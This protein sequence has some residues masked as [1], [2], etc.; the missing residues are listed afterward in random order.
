[1]KER[2]K[3]TAGSIK[4]KNEGKNEVAQRQ[5][6]GAEAMRDPT[7]EGSAKAEAERQQGK[8]EKHDRTTQ[9]S[10]CSLTLHNCILERSEDCPKERIECQSCEVSPVEQNSVMAHGK[11]RG[12]SGPP[13]EGLQCQ[14]AAVDEHSLDSQQPFGISDAVKVDMAAHMSDIKKCG[15]KFWS[16][17]RSMKSEAEGVREAEKHS[18]ERGK[19]KDITIDLEEEL[20]R[21]SDTESE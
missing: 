7:R 6:E 18:E 20:S 3:W 2:R 4:N 10:E 12:L 14:S 17:R 16:D 21:E 11:E 15:W 13:E 5:S 8:D 1:M 9:T 19:K